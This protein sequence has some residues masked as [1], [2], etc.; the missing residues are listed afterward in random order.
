[1]A[2][3]LGQS[4]YWQNILQRSQDPTFLLLLVIW[5]A[6]YAWDESLEILYNHICSLETQVLST[7][8]IT[9]TR[10]LHLIRAHLL[11]YASLLG[12]LKKTVVFILDT[13]NPAME[14]YPEAERQLS[15]LL[16]VKECNNLLLETDRLESSRQMQDKRLKNVMNLVGCQSE[17]NV[18]VQAY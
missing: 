1:M 15:R 6:M 7:S 18:C 12:D 8:N 3:I 9:I 16:L 13:E 11:H 10:E 4:V 17:L 2:L 5:H 14:V